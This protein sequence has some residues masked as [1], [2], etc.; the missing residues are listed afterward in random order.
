MKN[1]IGTT[2]EGYTVIRQGN[3]VV[4]AYNSKNEMYVVWNYKISNSAEISFHWGRY[5]N[6]LK[7]ALEK[8]HLKAKGQYSG[9]YKEEIS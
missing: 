2:N 1:L 6:S 3:R 7:T 9:F 4:M 8:Y 5:C